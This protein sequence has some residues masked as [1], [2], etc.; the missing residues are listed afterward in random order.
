[1]RRYCRTGVVALRSSRPR[2]RLCRLHHQRL[3]GGVIPIIV[4]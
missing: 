1:L 3:C 2:G 4:L